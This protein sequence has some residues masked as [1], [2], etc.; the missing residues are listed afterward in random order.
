M[1]AGPGLGGASDEE[2][3]E[4]DEEA[5][6]ARRAAVRER[7]ESWEAGLDAHGRRTRGLGALGISGRVMRALG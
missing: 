1:G 6:A 2:Q 5:L 4:E 7:C 3:E